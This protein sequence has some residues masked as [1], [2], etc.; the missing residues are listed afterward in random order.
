MRKG[1]FGW[2]A[3]GR[4]HSASER[5][6]QISRAFP[7]VAKSLGYVAIAEASTVRRSPHLSIG[8]IS[9]VWHSQGASLISS[10]TGIRCA[11]DTVALLQAPGRQPPGPNLPDRTRAYTWRWQLCTRYRQTAPRKSS[12]YHLRLRNYP[13][14]APAMV[15][16]H[17]AGV[18]GVVVPSQR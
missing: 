5:L 13:W 1:L 11:A 3:F 12:T 14:Q 17:Y 8:L 10:G 4:W 6:L 18:Y 2:I 9:A 7:Q 16:R 15:R